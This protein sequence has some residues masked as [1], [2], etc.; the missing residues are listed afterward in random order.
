[1]GPSPGR[2]RPD[3]GPSQNLRA[4]ADRKGVYVDDLTVTISRPRHE[5][6][7]AEV[8]GTGARIKLTSDDGDVSR[9]HRH[10]FSRD[11]RTADGHRRAPE[12]VI[13][14]RP[15]CMG[16]DC[17][18]GSPRG[19]TGD[20]AARRRWAIRREEVFEVRRWPRARLFAATGVTSGDFL[21]GSGSSRVARRPTRCDA[22]EEPYHSLHPSPEL[23]S[24]TSRTSR[25]LDS[26]LED[27]RLNRWQSGACVKLALE[28]QWET[29]RSIGHMRALSRS[30]RGRRDAGRVPRC[31]VQELC[32]LSEF[33][34]KSKA[35]RVGIAAGPTP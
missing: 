34:R 5:K 31:V 27:P 4:I 8:R 11:G 25:R 18:G 13:A 21:R 26:R 17:R 33:V 6:L 20:R 3:K 23:R 32:A 30:N 1:V 14:A 15:P 35:V 24:S 19:T 9:G 16:G 22:L 28:G 2:H 7:I 29:V 10:L 12:G